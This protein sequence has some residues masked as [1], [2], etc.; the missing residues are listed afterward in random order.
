VERIWRQEGLKVPKRQAKRG[1]LWLGD[2]S[3]IRKRPEYRDHVCSYDFVADRTHDGRPLRM[4]TVIDEYSR[5]GL[6]IEEG[7]VTSTKGGRPRVIPMTERLSKA[8]ATAR[9]LQSPRVLSQDDGTPFTQK[10][11]QTVVWNAARRANLAGVGPHRLR[12]TF[13]SHLA[14]RGAPARAIQE[15]C[16]HADLTTTQ[17]Y[18]HLSPDAVEAAIRLL[19]EPTYPASRGKRVEAQGPGG[20]RKVGK[21]VEAAGK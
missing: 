1:R 16:G 15:L 8:L 4:H 21:I 10:E 7:Q 14:M 2:G 19:D 17:R 9:H 13:A 5:E 20:P 12:H 6:A 18:M 3:C 11:L